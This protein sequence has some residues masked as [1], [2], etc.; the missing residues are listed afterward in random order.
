MQFDQIKPSL[1]IFDDFVNKGIS[2]NI[3]GVNAMEVVK[4][5]NIIRDFINKNLDAEN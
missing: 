2:A 1:E 4:A 5:Y 3:E